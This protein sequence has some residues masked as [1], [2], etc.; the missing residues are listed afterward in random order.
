MTRSAITSALV[1]MAAVAA[2][3]TLYDNQPAKVLTPKERDARDRI[4]RD[5]E[6]RRLRDNQE[7]QAR[8]Q[9]QADAGAAPYRETRRRR[10]AAKLMQGHWSGES[11]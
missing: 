6:R 11:A 9:A 1:A 8:R 7:Y 4:V 5:D 10:N 2:M 3:D